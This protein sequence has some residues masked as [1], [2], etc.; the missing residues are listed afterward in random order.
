MHK[1]I[2][3]C[4]LIAALILLTFF[5]GCT[6]STVKE[7]PVTVTGEKTPAEVHTA[8][9]I[10]TTPTTTKQMVTTP[11]ILPAGTK[12]H[13]FAYVLNGVKGT[14]SVSLSDS[15]Y[16][17]YA[18]K[19]DPIWQSPYNAHTNSTYYLAYI[20]DPEQQPAIAALAQAIQEKTPD[21][22]DQARIAVSLVQH[23]PYKVG[24]KQ[25]R[26]PYEVLY[27]N[28]GVCGEKSMLLALLLK[29]L[30]FGSSVYYFLPEDHMTV[31]IKAA[32]PYDFRNS[33]YAFIE[34][35]EP[36]IIT[37]STTDTLAQWKFTSTMEVTPVGTGDAL[38]SIASDYDDARQWAALAVKGKTLSTSDYQAWQALNTKYDMSYYT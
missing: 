18:K 28:Q 33:G 25:Y 21:K 20:D 17:D 36:Y 6:S 34:A 30:G 14:G 16:A 2:F 26:Y 1:R 19:P 23:I 10:R 37:D 24:G 4:L 35:T 5:S 27:Q 9:E 15:V 3:S 13:T 11:V 7:N 22:D 38:Q 12:E 8:A 32:S 31:G 29:D